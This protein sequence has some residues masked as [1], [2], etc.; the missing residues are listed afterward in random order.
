MGDHSS[1]RW[2]EVRVNSTANQENAEF[3]SRMNEIYANIINTSNHYNVSFHN[4]INQIAQEDE[5]ELLN[6]QRDLH[7]NEVTLT[8]TKTI[9]NND[10]LI[11]KLLPKE[12]KEFS[13]VFQVPRGLPPSRGKWDFKLKITKEDL[14]K[15]PLAKAKATSKEVSFAMKEMIQSYMKEG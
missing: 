14:R 11:S 13:D 3:R 2:R 12:L 6:L 4:I 9:L 8:N 5:S 15:L 10:K 1:T 7:R